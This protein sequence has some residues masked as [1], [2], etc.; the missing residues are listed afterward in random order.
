MA[1]NSNTKIPL[2]EQAYRLIKEQVIA[3]ELG[4][5]AQVDEGLLAARLDIGRTPVRE[6]ILRLRAERI[7]EAVPGRG[8]FVRSLGL[9]DVRSLFEAL[10]INERAVVVLAARRIGPRSLE[11]LRKTNQELQAAMAAGDYLAVTLLNN[12]F[13]RHIHRASEN[14]FLCSALEHVQNQA[15]RLAYL[16]FSQEA[17]PHD[18]D[19]H[20]EKVTAHHERLI[21]LLGQGDQE[22]LLTV[23]TDHIQLFH[24]RVARYTS[25]SFR[26]LDLLAP[27]LKGEEEGIGQGSV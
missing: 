5:G 16:C 2:S 17:D 21:Q 14:D 20:N 19:R 9:E 18:L 12:R 27:D 6:A 22:T 25:P 26:G 3:L 11:R 7:L 8:Y 1:P 15:Q 4:P 13:H 10:M 23:M 24:D